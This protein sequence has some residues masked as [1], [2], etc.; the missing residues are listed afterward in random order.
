M[1]SI[2]KNVVNEAIQNKKV[3][4]VG[5]D[6]LSDVMTVKQAL[7]LATTA[8]L[9]LV[10]VSVKEGVSVCKLMDYSKFLYEQKKREKSNQSKKEVTKEIKF[11]PSIAEHDLKI[12]AKS[13][14]NN[15]ENGCRIRVVVMFK[16]REVDRIKEGKVLLE[17]FASILPE[18]IMLVRTPIIEGR[19]YIMEL[20]QGK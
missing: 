16:G 17:K 3:Q 14:L 20:K 11:S 13:A 7:E 2:N 15:L 9:D 5:A 4:I 18:N 6:G 8:G 19:N 12:K 1:G 10:E